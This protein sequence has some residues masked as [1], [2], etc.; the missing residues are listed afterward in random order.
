MIDFFFI[1]ELFFFIKD[2]YLVSSQVSKLF[3]NFLRFYKHLFFTVLETE[4]RR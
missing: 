2:N 4:F 1:V 3:V